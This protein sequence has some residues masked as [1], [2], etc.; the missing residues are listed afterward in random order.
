VL[1]LVLHGRYRWV[2]M[3]AVA[4]LD[5]AAVEDLRDLVW[6]PVEVRFAAGVEAPVTGFMPTRYPHAAAFADD[7]L[8][9]ARSTDWSEA[10]HGQG[11]RMWT[12]DHDDVAVL[13][14]RRVA[15]GAAEG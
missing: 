2:P 5:L 4:G 3:D 7:G 12:T 11:Q 6:L 9:L 1:E 13:E 8:R 10:G 15:F 14:H